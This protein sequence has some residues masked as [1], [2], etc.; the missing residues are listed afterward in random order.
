MNYLPFA[1]LGSRLELCQVQGARPLSTIINTSYTNKT[2]THE[3]LYFK[4][5]KDK[6][7]KKKTDLSEVRPLSDNE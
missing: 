2:T 4:Q 3:T 7:K 6:L 1:S 5:L